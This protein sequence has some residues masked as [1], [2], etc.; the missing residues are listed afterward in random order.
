MTSLNG[1][2]GETGLLSLA[3][4]R[5]DLPNDA[6]GRCNGNEGRMDRKRKSDSLSPC[7]SGAAPRQGATIYDIRKNLQKIFTPSLLSAFF[8]FSFTPSR[9]F[10]NARRDDKMDIQIVSTPLLPSSTFVCFSVTLLLP[11]GVQT[12]RRHVYGSPPKV[13]RRSARARSTAKAPRI[14]RIGETQRL[15]M[16]C[17]AR[18]AA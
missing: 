14:G 5:A 18:S 2:S 17:N 4:S 6:T 8:C 3:G 12:L 9:S 13:D 11:P 16:R 15:K 7:H 10:K 1:R